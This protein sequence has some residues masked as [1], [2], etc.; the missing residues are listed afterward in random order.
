MERGGKKGEF[1]GW[2]SRIL[3]LRAFP[4]IGENCAWKNI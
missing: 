4:L 2:R 3:P 1:A